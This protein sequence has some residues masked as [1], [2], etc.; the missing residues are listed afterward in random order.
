MNPWHHTNTPGPGR[1]QN[2]SKSFQIPVGGKFVFWWL[3]KFSKQVLWRIILKVL[4][5]RSKLSF[6]AIHWLDYTYSSVAWLRAFKTLSM[7]RRKEWSSGVRTSDH[8]HSLCTSY[9]FNN[10]NFQRSAFIYR[11]LLSAL[12]WTIKF[13]QEQRIIFYKREILI[14]MKPAL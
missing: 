10:L 2:K 7:Q 1:K 4:T 5:V 12:H 8:L 9:C 3:P 11:T 14:T 13:N 6:V